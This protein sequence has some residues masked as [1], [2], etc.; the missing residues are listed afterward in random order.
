MSMF[1]K[2]LKSQAGFTLVEAIAVVGVLAVTTGILLVNNRMNQ[3]QLS[4]N[5]DIAGIAAAVSR[6]KALTLQGAGADQGICGYGVTFEQGLNN[7]PDTYSIYSY[8]DCVN[9]IKG[10]IVSEQGGANA[11]TSGLRILNLTA[12]NASSQFIRDV[13]FYSSDA[14]VKL[15]NFNGQSIC[16][17]D[18]AVTS[19]AGII[20]ITTEVSPA[21]YV[22]LKIATTG[23]VT[24]K[25]GIYVNVDDFNNGVETVNLETGETQQGD[26]EETEESAFGDDQPSCIASCLCA[27]S[28]ASGGTCSDGCGGLC[29][30]GMFDGGC[31]P[32]PGSCQA[33]NNTC[34]DRDNCRAPCSVC[35]GGNEVCNPCAKTCV[36]YV[37]NDQGGTIDTCGKGFGACNGC[38]ASGQGY[39]C[40]IGTISCNPDESGGSV[41]EPG[42]IGLRLDSVWPPEATK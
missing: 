27:S 2:Y 14:R 9:W 13:I 11:L 7:N 10:S 1:K 34:A 22:T 19:S 12:L 30:A 23:Q 36:Q 32:N 26:T 21:S 24:S 17:T 6:A 39:H 41:C 35:S 37:C 18:C 20:I 16:E 31:T 28:L 42:Q 4:L 25:S 38:A 5:A 3:T 29:Y 15:F 40:V 8:T 33:P